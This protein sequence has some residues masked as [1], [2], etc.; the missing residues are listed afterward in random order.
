[1]V[2]SCSESA[3]LKSSLP[4]APNQWQ[5]RITEVISREDILAYLTPWSQIHDLRRMETHDNQMCTSRKNFLSPNYKSLL[6]RAICLS[7]FSYLKSLMTA[8]LNMS[9]KHYLKYFIY[10]VASDLTCG[11]RYLLFVACGIWFS[12]QGW[13]QTPYTG[14]M[15]F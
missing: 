5:K 8:F 4:G 2:H 7:L 11:M 1:M 12:D 6:I 9:A 13:N 15:E 10:L 14:S 3:W